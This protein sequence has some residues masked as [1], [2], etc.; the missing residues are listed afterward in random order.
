MIEIAQD[1]RAHVILIDEIAGRELIALAVA[2]ISLW[3]SD[4]RL[5]AQSLRALP[6]EPASDELPLVRCCFIVF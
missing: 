1:I 2:R 5:L 6:P 4:W 3:R